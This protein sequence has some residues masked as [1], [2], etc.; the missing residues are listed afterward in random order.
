MNG[1]WAFAIV[2]GL[3]GAASGQP[4]EW[5]VE[6]GGNGH[7]YEPVH[8]SPA[9]SPG[10]WRGEAARAG[11]HLATVGS[12]AENQ[13]LFDLTINRGA[14]VGN[15][16][17]PL[18][19]A[20]K[21]GAGAMQWL[22]GEPWNYAAWNAG[23]PSG[24][25]GEIF[26]M[27]GGAS[28]VALW[29]DT[30][31]TPRQWAIF[32]WDGDCDADGLIDKGQIER[33]QRSDEDLNGVPD[34]CEVGRCS[35]SFGP[36]LFFE[37]TPRGY[38]TLAIGDFNGD[39]ASDA[40][41][42]NAL[43]GQAAVLLNDA[44]GTTFSRTN[45]NVSFG[46]S[47]LAVADLNSDGVLDAVIPGGY[48]SNQVSVLWGTPGGT[49][50]P[51]PTHSLGV[52]PNE[53][54]FGDF[55]GDGRRDLAV[56]NANSADVTLLLQAP[57]PNSGT[58]L[59]LGN[60]PFGSL[61]ASTSTDI[62]DLNGDGR[63]DLVVGIYDGL[64]KVLLSTSAPGAPG[65]LPPVDVAVGHNIND[66]AIHD[67]DGDG[68]MEVV[69]CGGQDGTITVLAGTADNPL[70]FR[71]L[72]VDHLGANPGR[73]LFADFNADGF[74]DM[75]VGMSTSIVLYLGSTEGVLGERVTLP[76][77]GPGDIG[78][79]NADGR[80]DLAYA[81]FAVRLNTGAGLT[82]P[83]SFPREPL[84][85][86]VLPG[87]TAV[88]SAEAG[89]GSVMYQWRKAGVSLSSDGRVTGADEPTLAVGGMT[90]A[91]QGMYDCLVTNPCGSTTSVAV[92]LSCRPVLIPDRNLVAAS[93]AGSLGARW[94][95][96]MAWD[97]TLSAFV[98]FGGRDPANVLNNDTLIWTGSNWIPASS[99]LRPAARTDHAMCTAP[100]G[101]VLLFG[102]KGADGEVLGDTW[103]FRGGQWSQIT[104]AHSPGPR[105]GFGM[106]FDR[107]RNS[108]VL[109]GGFGPGANPTYLGETWVWNG[110]DWT[111]ASQGGPAARFAHAMAFDPGR[112]RVVMF[113]G[114][115]GSFFN[116][117]WTWN[118][119]SW[120]L[121]PGSAPSARFYATLQEDAAS[122][123]LLLIGGRSASGVVLGDQWDLGAAGWSVRFG[124]FVGG[125]IAFHAAVSSPLGEMLLSG[126]KFN[127]AAVSATT[128]WGSPVVEPG[129]MPLVANTQLEV[130]VPPSTGYAFRWRQNGQNLFNSPGLFSGVTTRVLTLLAADPSLAG[131]YDCVITNACGQ[132]ISAPVRVFCPADFNGD[133]FLDF[134][135]YDDFVLAFETGGGLEADFNRDGFVDFFDYDDF[136][137]AFETG[138]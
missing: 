24:G 14:W 39:G 127:G 104:P 97:S 66:L 43:F 20:I 128:W 90:P 8:G 132:T 78:D 120:S 96:A 137:R 44:F 13:F 9:I 17:G 56:V 21:D 33:G 40:L 131:Q 5:R 46:A 107:T 18:L 136:V 106:A 63:D 89:G 32:E 72:R 82:R 110:S 69:V 2:F 52:F 65:F 119:A 45:L 108:A 16:S 77:S 138:C 125:P 59:H 55:D 115:N 19:G 71:V 74:E 27:F 49:F 118:G 84:S 98:C 50:V 99:A 73:L 102:G 51:G 1:A 22:T 10:V 121:L 94:V 101:G 15:D 48:I 75:L 100:G 53:P 88:I 29:R 3:A 95:H 92:D 26:L 134:F 79:F 130:R 111:L 37:L 123:S 68:V 126:G 70:V 109:F 64:V 38:G 41:V 12:A 25:L 7:W 135:D 62:A 6:D 117:S 34:T 36:P 93:D 112:Q 47:H 80:P 114:Y 57:P 91:D 4:V 23:E 35:L 31:Q 67:V 113:G 122:Q 129:V 30:D 105:G 83:P 81:G 116:D 85:T 76:V 87:Q 61:P 133:G 58:L 103:L 42:G 124:P 11:A 28:P 54:V 86:A 60:F